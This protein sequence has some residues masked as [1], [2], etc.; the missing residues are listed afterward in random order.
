MTQLEANEASEAASRS[1]P[2]LEKTARS[3]VEIQPHLDTVADIVVFLEVLGYTNKQVAEKGFTDLFEFADQLYDY[4]GRYAGRGEAGGGL[5]EREAVKIPSVGRRVAEGLTLSFPWIGSLSVLFLFG[6]SLWLVWGLPASITTSL[7]IG[8]FLG[9]FA[10]EGPMQLFQ[11]LFA[12]HYNQANL[13][14]VKR[15]LKRSYGVLALLAGAVLL[16]LYASEVAWGIPVSLVELTAIA[17]VS[18]LAHRVS[19]VVIYA[20]KRYWQLAVSYAAGLTAMVGSYYLLYNII[21][22][23][24]NRYL[25]SLGIAFLVLSVA[26]IYYDYKVFSSASTSS[27]DDQI[28]HSVNPSIV[29]SRTIRSSFGVQLW[30]N[31]PYYAFGT[32]FFSLLFGD[33]V[34]A[35]LFN[36]NHLANGIRLPLE[37]NSAYHLGADLAL[38]VIFP[39]AV[40]Q[41]VVMSP[42]SEH[43]ANLGMTT[44]VSDA[45]A[46]DGFLRER[47]V[48][49]LALTAVASTSVAAVLFIAG[50]HI[51]SDLGGSEVSVRILVVAASGNVLIS[52]FMANSLYL[53]FASRIKSLV[54]IAC[55]GVTVLVLGGVLLARSGFQDIVYAY[56]AAAALTAI[57]S[58]LEVSDVLKS[59]G[60]TFFSRY[61]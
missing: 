2:F 5:D 53:T 34:L 8:L 27:I 35:W 59:P 6:V 26:P 49:L 25:D 28:R 42:I 44:K 29:N 39:A 47:Y 31:L 4:I 46:V 3:L 10:S 21:P 30:E 51:I 24:L 20:L 1:V 50:P 61:M 11:R 41:Y 55:V 57:L 33:R 9:I 16:L 56:F 14:E 38:I 58:S 40:I 7:I 43:L 45:A 12:F 52:I 23:T 60:R 36:P 22:L 15:V 32:L 37:F 13:S 18:I 48:L 19:Y 54:V 17:S